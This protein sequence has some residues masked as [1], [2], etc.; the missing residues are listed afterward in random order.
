MPC[1]CGGFT[2]SSG[3]CYDK[4][5]PNYRA[6]RKPRPRIKKQSKKQAKLARDSNPKRGGVINSVQVCDSCGVLATDTH[7]I[8]AGAARRHLA[9]ENVRALSYLCRRCHDKWQGAPPDEQIAMV[10]RAIIRAVNV[11]YGSQAVDAEAVANQLRKGK[12]NVQ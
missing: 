7:E 8:P 1:V 12:Q 11:C 5:C 4:T 9:M 10:T 3:K 6:T 2:D